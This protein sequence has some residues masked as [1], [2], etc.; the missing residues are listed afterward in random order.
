LNCI[1]Y[2]SSAGHVKVTDET[3]PLL[4]AGACQAIGEIS[5]NA[6]LP[7]PPGD[8][9]AGEGEITKLSLVKNLLAII[10]SGKENTKVTFFLYII[11]GFNIV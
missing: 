2:S 11:T 6:A 1:L 10:K 4:G 5:R 3:S 7:L 8:E 9:S